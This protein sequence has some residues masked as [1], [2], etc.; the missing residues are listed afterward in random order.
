[1]TEIMCTLVSAGVQLGI[2][3]EPCRS[4][5][6]SHVLGE[7]CILEGTL[8]RSVSRFKNLEVLRL[9][10][11]GMIQGSLPT[12]LAELTKLQRLDVSRNLITG[13][14]PAQFRDLR[15]LEEL[16]L[17]SNYLRGSIPA[18]LGDLSNLEE[19]IL[20]NNI[21]SGTIPRSLGTLPKVKVVDISDND[22]LGPIPPFTSDFLRTLDLVSSLCVSCRHDAVYHQFSFAC[23]YF[24]SDNKQLEGKLDWILGNLT[25]KILSFACTCHILYIRVENLIPPSH[26]YRLLHTQ[27]RTA[28]FLGPFLQISLLAKGALSTSNFR[29]AIW[30]AL[31]HLLF[32]GL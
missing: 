4:L 11:G 19:L 25:D 21:F 15:T 10:K 6:I 24:Q 20:S 18:F 32:R 5:V 28:S 7:D 27:A 29:L 31:S 1:M 3:A 22:L 30:L 12:Q 16:D 13:V 8:P 2:R 9:D 17:G 14:I 26:S 23:V